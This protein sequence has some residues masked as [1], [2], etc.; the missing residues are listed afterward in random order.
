VS[1]PRFGSGDRLPEIVCPPPGPRS[2]EL[3]ERLGRF[4]A[5]GVNTLY[6]GRPS[7]VWQ[8]ALGANVL[9]VDGNRYID[10]TAGFGVAGVGHRR[11]EVV[12]AVR[13]QA[14]VLLHGL[15]DVA[16]HPLRVEL[17]E[18]LATLAPI[19][20]AQVHFAVSGSDAVE[21]A[22]ATAWLHTGRR[23]FVAFEPAYHGTT[24]GALAATSRPAFREPFAAQLNPHVHRL[25]HGCSIDQIRDL[26]ASNADIAAALVEPIPGR[27]GHP[28]PPDG[29]L[30][31]VAEVCRAHGALLIADEIYTGFG[32]TGAMF[33]CEADGVEPDILCC[34]KALGG[35]LPIAAVLAS[36]EC[37][38]AWDRGGEALHTATFLAHPLACAAAMAALDILEADDLTT[39]AHRLGAVATGRA[40]SW[41]QIDGV[42]SLRG[43]GLFLVLELT[44]PGRAA[45]LARAALGRGLLCLASGSRVQL[46]PPLTITDEQWSCALDL[47][48]GL[49]KEAA[50]SRSGTRG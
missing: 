50:E 43:R 45:S 22:L 6:G 2:L 26:L 29:W 18:R 16:A 12:E 24:L 9:D 13:E 39:R 20:D 25:P 33:A 40:T 4:E 5:P 23:S 31:D 19:R 7:V 27:E 36:A 44:T 17:S 11:P 38:A 14:G 3:S 46:A 42:S 48:E 41:A 30:A 37:F 47:I 10:L 35:G 49:L 8:E 1:D 32:R 34:G 21:I 28:A 15:A